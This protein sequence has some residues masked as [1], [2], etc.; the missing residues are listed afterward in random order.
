M[1][2]VLRFLKCLGPIKCRG[3]DHEYR[4]GKENWVNDNSL[5]AIVIEVMGGH[6]AIHHFHKL[7]CIKIW[8]P[9][10]SL[11]DLIEVEGLAHFNTRKQKIW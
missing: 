3:G 11:D 2:G 8:D 4:F 5:A 6:R 1:R 7:F 10:L 9:P